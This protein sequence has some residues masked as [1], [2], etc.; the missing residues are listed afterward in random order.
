MS[1]AE[2]LTTI[3]EN[4]QRVYSAGATAENKAFW[5]RIT[6]NNTRPNY[7]RAFYRWCCEYIR[8]PYKI[9]PTDAQS[10]T[11]TFNSN[12]SLK[13]VEKEYFDLS[14]RA[15]DA[16]SNGYWYY[17]FSGCTNILEIEDIGFTGQWGY[18]ATFRNCE[19][20]HTIEK[21]GTDANTTWD[22]NVFAGCVALENLTIE[23]TIGKNNFNVSECTKL[24]KASLLSILNACN[25]TDL[26]QTI[27]VTL[28]LHCID[29]ETDTEA[30]M[31]ENGD[32][33]LY[34]TLMSARSYGY[35][36][37]FA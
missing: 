30:L 12:P 23:G 37:A 25:K 20:L 16:T 35:S 32:E 36:F 1:I 7:N 11:Y 22:R 19:K 27:T 2:K 33:N 18:F 29:G 5:D 26:S 15:L 3:A 9:V 10:A 4:E 31:S 24:S 6:S 14:Q 28:P 34:N 8:P 13:K 21:I 17:T